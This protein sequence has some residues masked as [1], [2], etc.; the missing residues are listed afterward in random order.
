MVKLPGLPTLF[1][2]LIRADLRWNELISVI[3]KLNGENLEEDD[4]SNMDFFERCHYLSLNPV[5]LA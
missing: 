1:M 4:I 3:A 5:V 2:T